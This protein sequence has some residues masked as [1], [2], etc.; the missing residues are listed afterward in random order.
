M[1]APLY[2]KFVTV[3]HRELE[4]I[5]SVCSLL[6]VDVNVISNAECRAMNE[7]YSTRVTDTMICAGVTGGGKVN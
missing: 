7:L 6:T 1:S 4:V 2:I 5:P 3:I